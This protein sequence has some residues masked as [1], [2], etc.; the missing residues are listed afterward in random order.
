MRP[1]HA[2]K[3]VGCEARSPVTANVVTNRGDKGQEILAS[4]QLARGF[5]RKAV[6][7]NTCRDSS[8]IADASFAVGALRLDALRVPAS[9]LQWKI[10]NELFAHFLLGKA[11][12]NQQDI[13][14]R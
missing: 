8:V 14:D 13:V 9:L 4:G 10:D 12:G 3:P 6:V 2:G 5:V 7:L 11:F 1:D